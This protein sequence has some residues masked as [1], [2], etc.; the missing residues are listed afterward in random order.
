M[1][2]IKKKSNLFLS[3]FLWY[4]FDLFLYYQLICMHF[5]LHGDIIHSLELNHDII[6]VI[7]MWFC[8]M[9][10]LKMQRYNIFSIYFTNICFVG[11]SRFLAPSAIISKPLCALFY[12]FQ[13]NA[14]APLKFNFI[15]NVLSP[16][17][18]KE[19][20]FIKWK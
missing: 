16:E 5:K 6:I 4:Q 14:R 20:L 1:H 10:S 12:A 17:L 2:L 7:D 3:T 11:C 18:F 15:L 13:C 8:T 19:K 9:L